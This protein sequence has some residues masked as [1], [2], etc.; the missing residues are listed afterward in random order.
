[1]SGQKLSKR[2][3]DVSVDD[4]RNKG[5]LPEA[6]L[7]GLALLGWNPPQKEDPDILSQDLNS[8]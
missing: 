5:F 7:N 4:Y 6:L 3:G 1:M 8:I 2:H